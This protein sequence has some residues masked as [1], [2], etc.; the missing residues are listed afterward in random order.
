M[1]PGGEKIFWLHTLRQMSHQGYHIFGTL[2]KL[3]N[4]E[5]KAARDF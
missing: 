4:I 2:I 5:N 3:M 1:F